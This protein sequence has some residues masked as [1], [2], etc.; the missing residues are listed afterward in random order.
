M[1]IAPVG[2]CIYALCM[3]RTKIEKELK[4]WCDKYEWHGSDMFRDMLAGV[5]EDAIRTAERLNEQSDYAVIMALVVEQQ[6]TIS[7]LSK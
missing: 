2:I 1:P 5:V 3:F 6:K 7:R 4:A